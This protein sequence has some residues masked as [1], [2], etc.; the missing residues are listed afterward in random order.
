MAYGWGQAP[1]ISIGLS[2][3]KFTGLATPLSARI[4]ML[5]L[6]GLKFSSHRQQVLGLSLGLLSSG[7]HDVAYNL[8]WRSLTDPS[9]MSSETSARQLG[10]SLFSAL[11]YAYKID[12][13]DSAMRPTRGHA[14]V[15]TTQIG[16]LFPDVQSLRLIRQVLTSIIV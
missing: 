13:R 9:Q 15:S 4:S 3:P 14:F 5:S 7:N 16:G 8:S 1:E 6:E 11:K 12:R 10:R 2:L